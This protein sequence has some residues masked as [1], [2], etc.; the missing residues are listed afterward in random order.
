MY[1]EKI[2]AYIDSR[3][4]ELLNDLMTLVRIDSQKG[5]PLEGKP[6]GTGEG[7]L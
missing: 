7:A 6:F 3:K 5:E 1:K 2:D 4:E